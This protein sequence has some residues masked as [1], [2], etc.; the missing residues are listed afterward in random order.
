[1]LSD[2]ELSTELLLM[3]DWFTDELFVLPETTI[4]R[5]P[6]SR[7]LVDVERFPDD[8]QEPMSRERIGDVRKII[9]IKIFLVS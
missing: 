5:F 7:L 6:I 9:S 8:I 4:L 2:N 3:T 1:M